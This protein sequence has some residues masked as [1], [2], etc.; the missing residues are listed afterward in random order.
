MTRLVVFVVIAVPLL[1]T[2]CK[3]VEED[4]GEIVSKIEDSIELPDEDKSKE[5][6]MLAEVKEEGTNVTD[7]ADEHFLSYLK[8]QEKDVDGKRFWDAYRDLFWGSDSQ[9]PERDLEKEYIEYGL[10][11][12]NNDGQNELIIR[13]D[14]YLIL[15]VIEYKNGKIIYANANPSKGA[16]YSL[17]TVENMYLYGDSYYEGN[18]HYR[19]IKIDTDGN[20]NQI[21]YFSK[22]C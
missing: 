3:T 21:L 11:D 16:L 12:M 1:F 22:V 5:E 20:A 4:S 13:K 9:I 10:V 18:E 17:I 8:G 7:V 6:L 19:V 14:G 2:G 15:D